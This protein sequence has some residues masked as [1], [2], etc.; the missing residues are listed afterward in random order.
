MLHFA[1]TISE[2]VKI[3]NRKKSWLSNGQKKKT[4]RFFL[5]SVN[6]KCW[7]AKKVV[8]GIYMTIVG[9]R[10]IGF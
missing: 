9:R 3:L 10:Q 4:Q 7:K 5:G 6:W 1:I 2:T 8:V